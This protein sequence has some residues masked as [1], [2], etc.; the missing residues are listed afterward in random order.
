MNLSLG[1][2]IFNRKIQIREQWLR[3]GR[4]CMYVYMYV[5][6]KRKEP[7]TSF[8]QARYERIYGRAIERYY[9]RGASL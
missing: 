8:L 7:T 2:T 4:L 3:L 6:I 1:T 9:V 5:R